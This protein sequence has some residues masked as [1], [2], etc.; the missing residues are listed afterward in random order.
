MK[1]DM[2]ALV[3]QLRL[4]GF[5]SWDPLG[6]SETWVEGD[7]T[8]GEYHSQLTSAFR[9]VKNLADIGAVWP[10]SRRRY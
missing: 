5:G 3:P 7:V 2:L 8:T 6:L 9:K 1:P 4:I 10:V